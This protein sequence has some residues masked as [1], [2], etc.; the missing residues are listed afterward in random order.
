MLK[1][2]IQ[3]DLKKALIEKREL[4]LSVLRMLSAAIQSSEKE[5]R[6]GISKEKTQLNSTELEKESQLTDEET[7]GVLSSEAK[8]RKEAG[9][10]FS[11]AGRQ[12]L[13]EKEKK[14]L[15]ILQ[16]YLP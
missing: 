4:E 7:L 9:D 8:K 3:Q 14:E 6:Y 13:A 10:V 16:K 5:K 11:R 12:D 1:E 15:E 2:R